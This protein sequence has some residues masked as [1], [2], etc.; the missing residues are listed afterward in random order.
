MGVIRD[1]LKEVGVITTDGRG[2]HGK[3]FLRFNCAC[4]KANCE[5]AIKAMKKVFSPK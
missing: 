3:T 2:Y 1:K 4:P 5:K